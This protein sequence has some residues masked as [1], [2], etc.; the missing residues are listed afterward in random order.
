M[1]LALAGGACLLHLVIRPWVGSGLPFLFFLSSVAVA[2]PWLGKGFCRNKDD[3]PRK[4][5]MICSAYLANE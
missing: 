1:G 5:D 4:S 3:G 2:A